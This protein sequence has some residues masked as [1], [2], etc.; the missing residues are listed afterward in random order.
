MAKKK[1]VF[2]IKSIGAIGNDKIDSNPL[3][4]HAI[5]VEEDDY[6]AGVTERAITDHAQYI[7]DVLQGRTKR[8]DAKFPGV[9]WKPNTAQTTSGTDYVNVEPDSFIAA[10]ENWT[11]DVLNKWAISKGLKYEY[12]VKADPATGKPASYNS[13]HIFL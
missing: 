4:E 12:I 2:Q 9:V 3:Y 1:I 8:D 6:Q 13:H 10:G 5:E 7:L 11:V